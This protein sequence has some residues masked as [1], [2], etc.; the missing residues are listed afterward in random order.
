[1]CRDIAYQHAHSLHR[2]LLKC[3]D[4]PPQCSNQSQNTRRPLQH[5]H[6]SH[7]TRGSLTIHRTASRFTDFPYTAQSWATIC[8]LTPQGVG[9]LHRPETR[10]TSKHTFPNRHSLKH[11]KFSN[12]S[13]SYI[14]TYLSFKAGTQHTAHP[15]GPQGKPCHTVQAL[16]PP[17]P[18]RI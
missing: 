3:T 5:K 8:R 12:S 4:P 18:N 11:T 2:G 13:Q 14:T 1:M 17:L 7:S 9:T 6:I 16:A 15:V 10:L